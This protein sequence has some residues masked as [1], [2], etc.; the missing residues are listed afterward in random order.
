MDTESTNTCELSPSS[1]QLVLRKDNR[2]RSRRVPSGRRTEANC[3]TGSAGRS[4]ADPPP[5]ADPCSAPLLEGPAWPTAAYAGTAKYSRFTEQVNVRVCRKKVRLA[6]PGRRRGGRAALSVNKRIS[7]LTRERAKQTPSETWHGDAAE[8]E[9]EPFT[10]RR[11]FLP[12]S[13]ERR[14]PLPMGTRQLLLV[15]QPTLPGRSSEG[16][17]SHTSYPDPYARGSGAKTRRQVFQP[18]P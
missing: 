12:S 2:R 6:V 13:Q 9:A 7:K 17:T 3:D 18:G 4:S 8:Q 5:P 10:L 14:T 1:A 16:V 15:V 11:T